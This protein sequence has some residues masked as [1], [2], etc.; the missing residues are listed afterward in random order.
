M[1]GAPYGYFTIATEPKHRIWYDHPP[2]VVHRV[3]C[4]TLKGLGTDRIAPQL[5]NDHV[6]SPRAYWLTMGIERLG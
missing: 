4:R 6:L 2:H 5:E 1:D 3:N